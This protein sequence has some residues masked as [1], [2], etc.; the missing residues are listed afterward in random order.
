MRL[1]GLLATAAALTLA[2]APLA[3]AAVTAPA[4]FGPGPGHGGH[5][6]HHGHQHNPWDDDGYGECGYHYCPGYPY[7]SDY[8]QSDGGHHGSPYG[9]RAD[10]DPRGRYGGG[11]GDDDGPIDGW[12]YHDVDGSWCWRNWC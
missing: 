1:A 4:P 10:H 5:A 6:F 2:V 7:G 11:W 12:S 8:G 9:A 3:S